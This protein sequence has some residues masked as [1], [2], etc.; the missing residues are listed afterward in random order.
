VDSPTLY[1]H[2]SGLGGE[3]VGNYA[4]FNPI[5][6][7]QQTITLSNGNLTASNPSSW[8]RA[9]GTI[10]VNSGKW[11]FESTPSSGN[12]HMTG[13]EQLIY[14]TTHIGGSAGTK[15]IA[16]VYDPSNTRGDISYN[17]SNSAYVGGNP[18][19]NAGDIIGVALDLD[20]NNV[21]FYKSGVLQYNLSNLLQTGAYYTF[22]VSLYS[23][24]TISAN[25]G[26]RAWA[27]SPP[28]GYSALTT[29][30]FA[31]PTGAAL[32]PNQFFDVV[33]W[34]GNGTS[35]TI[36]LPGAFQ[37]DLIWLKG[38]NNASWGHFLQ[39]SVR[40]VT[41]FLKSNTSEAA[42]TTS[43]NIVNTI[44]S[45]GF[46]I[47]ANGN[48]NNLND[49]YV[50]WCWKA[51]GAA[52]SNTNGTITSQVSANNTSGFSVVT[53]TGAGS[54][55]TSTVGHGL[56]TAPSV[57]FAKVRSTTNGW[58]VYHSGMGATYSG[59][60]SG[61]NAFTLQT[62]WNN[63]APTT[64]VFSITG[65]NNN[66]A[67]ATYVAY[68]WSEVPGFSKF[69][70]YTGNGNA[71]GP[72]IYCGF[73]PRWI[74][75]KEAT[76]TN[77]ATGSWQIFDTARDLGNPSDNRLKANV[78][79]AEAGSA[80]SW[81][82]VSNGFKLRSTNSNWNE[83]SGTYIFMAYAGSPFGNTNGTAR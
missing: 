74:M 40:G 69:G 6:A 57:I 11:Y 76:G 27:Y 41:E 29:K 71:D 67:S 13:V 77:A 19:F 16:L 10:A 9:M 28:Q 26:Q 1:G 23:G 3:V 60:L 56:G 75:V 37:P 63:T 24:G 32:T 36:T 80:P 4:T 8:V 34:T 43:P 64:S 22:G 55:V 47:L 79:D 39:D 21:K 66:I 81:D 68:C 12:W 78:S 20:N 51:G 25:F 62:D 31:R 52:V 53:Y 70:S 17:G 59:I 18:I 65:A 15:G 50:A 33:T 2:D 35:Q 73:K 42:G 54:G 44:T 46:T 30:N 61:G 48:S 38:R 49:T 5:Y 72:F 58:L 82:V 83:L 45:T 7:Q 14:G